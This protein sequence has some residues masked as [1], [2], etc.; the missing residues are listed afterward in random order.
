LVRCSSFAPSGSDLDR[1][2]CVHAELNAIIYA[3]RK[4]AM[5]GTVYTTTFPCL[6]C[7]KAIIQCGIKRVVY[8][9]DYAE[10]ENTRGV[11]DESHVQY[12]QI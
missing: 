9:Q 11:F 12:N 10:G 8:K 6:G 3:G 2:L 5:G 1:C 4:D 7:A